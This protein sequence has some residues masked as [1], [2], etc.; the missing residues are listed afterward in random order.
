MNIEIND[1]DIDVEEDIEKEDDTKNKE[2]NEVT[3]NEGIMTCLNK[4]I[5]ESEDASVKED[6]IATYWMTAEQHENFEKY[7]EYIVEIPA[8]GQNTPE[9][10]EA[11]YNRVEN[12]VRFDVFEEVDDC[13]QER[14]GSR[15]VVTQ[16]EQ[17]DGQK[18]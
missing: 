14:I 7:A 17:A 11:K 16:K 13:G 3:F 8:K 6:A 10:N 15:W 12:L 5:K 9:V 18:S 2:R 4:Q 1:N